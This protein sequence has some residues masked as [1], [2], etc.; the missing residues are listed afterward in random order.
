MVARWDANFYRKYK[1]AFPIQVIHMFPGMPSTFTTTAL[2]GSY[3]SSLYTPFGLHAVELDLSFGYVDYGHALMVYNEDKIT[4]KIY[5]TS[6]ICM[7]I[8]DTVAELFTDLQKFDIY[9]GFI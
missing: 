7:E 9:G 8:Q 3:T 6:E 2:Y 4:S 1:D 5:K